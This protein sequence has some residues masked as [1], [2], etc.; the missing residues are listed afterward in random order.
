M[1]VAKKYFVTSG[2]GVD[3]YEVASFDKALHMAGLGDYN[4]VR[5][6]SII[7]PNAKLC[8]HVD[9]P[10]GSVIFSAFSQ[11]ITACNE[12]IA[13]AVVAAIPKSRNKVGVIMEYSCVGNK[14]QAITIASKLAIEA[15]ERRGSMEFD[16]VVN[17][18]DAQGKEGVFTTTFSAIVLM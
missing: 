2:V 18:I 15:L 10:R 4:L 16:L 13:S 12:L 1:F 14:D 8:T 9:Y 11:N 7:P 5:V 3:E 6:S 17:G